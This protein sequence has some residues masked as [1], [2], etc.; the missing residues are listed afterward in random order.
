[1][2][3]H[4][5]LDE[6]DAQEQPDDRTPRPSR[7]AKKRAVE[8]YEVLAREVADMPLR[9]YSQLKVPEVLLDEV[10]QARR[11]KGGSSRKRQAKF[12]AGFFRRHE[13]ETRRL[14]AQLER[15]HVS[16]RADTVLFHSIEELRDRLCVPDQAPSALNEVR[17]QFP[18]LDFERLDQL[19]FKSHRTGDRRYKREIFRLLREMQVIMERPAKA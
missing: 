14:K 12:L 19:M 11:T 15:L 9:Q 13:E 5:R 18:D 1:M 16:H 6:P 4:D 7:G 2:D 3:E 8:M 10:A 17:A